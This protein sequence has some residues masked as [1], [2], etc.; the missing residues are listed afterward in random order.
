MTQ[1]HLLNKV[2]KYQQALNVGELH[3]LEWESLGETEPEI[4]GKQLP[5]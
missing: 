2:A 3:L 1:M 4:K 5:L